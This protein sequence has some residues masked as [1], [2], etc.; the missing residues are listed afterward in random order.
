MS[1]TAP[2]TGPLHPAIATCLADATA[3]KISRREFLTRATA[4]GASSLAAYG[5]LGLPRPAA[6]ATPL[7]GGTLRM[8]MEVRALKDPRAFDWTQMAYITAGWLEYLV[9]YNSDGTFEP[10]LLSGWEVNDNAT[11]YTLNVRQGVTWNS[12]EP[13]TA[14][15][16]ARVLSDWC[17]TQAPGNSMA[18]R[19][20]T[21][22]DPE[23]GRAR[24]GA[25]EVADRHTVK[26]HLP[27]PDIT[28]IAGMSDYPAAIYHS[29]IDRDDPASHPVGTG[30]YLPEVV[31]PGQR[32]VLVRNEDH[33]W[34][35]YDAG[36]GAHLDRI[37]YLDYGTDPSSWI[38]AAATDEVD[39]LYETVGEF[40]EVAESIGLEG[41][42]VASGATIVIRPNQTA[43][44][45]GIR[46]YAD[47]RVRRAIAMAV[48]NEVCL[49]LGYAD[50]GRVARN[51]HVGP[52][53]PEYADVPKIDHDP[54]AALAL[55]EEAGMAGFEM[56]ITSIDDDW[57][58]NTTDAVAA[59]L[60][61]AG[62]T[63]KRTIVPSATYRANWKDYAFSSTNWNHRPLGTQI[64]SLAYRSGAPWNE[65]G[66]SNPEFDALLDE[67]NAIADADKRREVMAKIQTILTEDA[68]TLQPYWRLLYRHAK[69]G[70][71]GWD[72]HIAYLPQIYKIGR[73]TLPDAGRDE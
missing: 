15:D 28:L 8:Q 54:A 13:F 22:I 42:E 58:R 46:P 20:A 59:Q 33:D 31:E 39:M 7:R 56:E 2:G 47:V 32:A 18:G 24:A 29:S 14:E 6:A 19:F 62:F 38:A 48:S 71:T 55:L 67:A 4:L 64:L 27:A 36:K 3:G 41:S 9:E 23:S 65:F 51:Q 73:T 66:Y 17:D 53:H 40:V 11:E 45:D 21:L 68:V 43:E 1:I 57:R 69:P 37:E 30:P 34:W 5:L 10:M 52:M 16:V 63:V 25:I 12:G 60:R 72:M 61:D 50:R 35:G 26:L 49:E 70:F 44:V